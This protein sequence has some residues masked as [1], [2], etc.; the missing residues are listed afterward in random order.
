MLFINK[1]NWCGINF[2]SKQYDGAKFDKA[3]LT[4]A[5]NVLNE[6]KRKYV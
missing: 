3:N 2:P 5:L 4:I 6:K 1:Y